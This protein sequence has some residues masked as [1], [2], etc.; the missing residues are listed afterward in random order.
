MLHHGLFTWK[1]NCYCSFTDVFIA[2]TTNIHNKV[3]FNIECFKQV[4]EYVSNI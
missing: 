3:S 2:V 1:V 4:F